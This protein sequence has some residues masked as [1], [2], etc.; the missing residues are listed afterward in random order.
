MAHAD[1]KC[2]HGVEVDGSPCVVLSLWLEG[3]NNKLSGTRSSAVK[4]IIR[5]AYKRFI[6]PF[7]FIRVFD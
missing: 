3:I 2:G 7:K 6:I 5:E 4:E 1:P